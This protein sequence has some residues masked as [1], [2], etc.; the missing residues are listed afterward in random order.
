MRAEEG[1][2]DSLS[3]RVLM[4]ALVRTLGMW[5]LCGVCVLLVACDQLVFGTGELETRRRFEEVAV[6]QAESDLTKRLGPPTAV[7]L[8]Q[9]DGSYTTESTTEA[10]RTLSRHLKGFK[11]PRVIAYLDGSVLAY[12]AIGDKQLVARRAIEIS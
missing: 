3:E 6:G 11:E 12:F 9:P 2:P 4:H 8:R 1:L 7:F 10:A 5:A